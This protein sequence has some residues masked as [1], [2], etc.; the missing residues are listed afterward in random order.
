MT[1]LML[2]RHGPTAWNTEKRLQGRT[3]IPLSEEGLRRVSGWRLPPEASEMIWFCS[4]LS[5]A[6]QTAAT[7]GLTATV[8][9]RL[10]E[11]DF[12]RWEGKRLSD[13]RSEDP[14]GMDREEARGLDMT[15]PGGESPRQVLARL[16][17]LLEEMARRGA[18]TGCVTHKGVIRAVFAAACAGI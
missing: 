6:Q 15:P 1:S 8:D 7:L 14:D 11:L 2:I 3:D 17:P 4:P 9:P 18:A 12:G 13:L 10:I 5:R 16:Q